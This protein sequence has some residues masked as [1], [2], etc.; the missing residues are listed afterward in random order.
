MRRLLHWPVGLSIVA[1]LVG[2][3]AAAQQLSAPAGAPAPSPILER[4]PPNE[5]SAAVEPAAIA[6]LEKMGAYLRTLKTFT[7]RADSIKDEVFD[8]GQKIQLNS[9]VEYRV[10]APD[11]L[12]AD[13]SSERQT[14]QFLYNGTTLTVYGRRVG[15]Y[16]TVPAPPTIAE[17]LQ[18][19]D[20]RYGLE[21]PLADLFLWGT[22]AAGL[23]D[24]NAGAYIGPSRIGD[25]DS[26]HYAYR[27]EGVDWQIWIQKGP[28]PLPRK[29]VI[30]TV[31]DADQP[32][33]VAVLTWNLSPKLDEGTFTFVPPRHAR[34]IVLREVEK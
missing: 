33:Y 13:V 16:A 2:L 26:D 27:Q 23:A 25:V 21:L 22:P 10:R 30:T 19:A 14:R 18:V 8:T 15:Y 32:Q 17:L 29:L 34:R 24:I 6:A 11:R 3:A 12:R 1:L 31:D 28:A 7:V 4:P 20:Q 5:T 9:V